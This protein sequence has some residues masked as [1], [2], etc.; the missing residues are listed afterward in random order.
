MVTSS[1]EKILDDVK[2]LSAFTNVTN[3]SFSK[4]N[5]DLAQA[6]K[7]MQKIKSGLENVHQALQDVNSKKWDI[8]RPL[9]E[10]I[11]TLNASRD[12]SSHH[13]SLEKLLPLTLNSFSFLVIYKITAFQ[14]W[15]P[16]PLFQYLL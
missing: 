12:V 2:N 9:D 10:L 6:I 16:T 7:S 14:K 8:L 4:P 3:V 15:N 13:N 1:F 11:N 5:E